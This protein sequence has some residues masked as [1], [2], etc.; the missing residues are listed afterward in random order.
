MKPR[1]F[2]RTVDHDKE[3]LCYAA[4]T[5]NELAYIRCIFFL[6]LY[7]D[8]N[9]W[10]YD[11]PTEIDSQY[12]RLLSCLKHPEASIRLRV[13]DEAGQYLFHLKL[14]TF[15]PKVIE[16]HRFAYFSEVQ[17]FIELD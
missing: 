3:E 10:P 4:L 17:R 7:D 5:S 12:E 11:E 6:G 1:K 8:S 16:N 2:H 14:T 13:A 9:Y 15:P